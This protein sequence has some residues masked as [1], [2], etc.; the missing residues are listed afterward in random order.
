MIAE[1]TEAVAVAVAHLQQ[2]L[3]AGTEG[4]LYQFPRAAVN[5]LPHIGWLK[6][7]C[8]TVLEIGG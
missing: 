5:K 8:L 6:T 1:G 4:N 7:N 2:L 3:K